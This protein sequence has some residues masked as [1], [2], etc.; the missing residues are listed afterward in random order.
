MFGRVVGGLEVLTAMERVDTDEDD[1]PKQP[2]K[3]T[4]APWRVTR[5][6]LQRRQRAGAPH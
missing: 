2:I 1:R 5:P 4:G 3:I 6:L